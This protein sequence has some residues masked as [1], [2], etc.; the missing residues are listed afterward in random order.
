[1]HDLK[2][3]SILPGEGIGPLH[4]GM[5]FHEATGQIGSYE[6]REL[7][8]ATQIICENFKIW[9]DH[10][11][12]RVAQILAH[13]SF[14]G[15]FDGWLVLGMTLSDVVKRGYS[16]HEELGVYMLDGVDG[17]CMELEDDC[18]LE[19][20]TPWDERAVPIARISVYSAEESV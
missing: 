20:D 10:A 14:E 2:I 18:A 12:D 1:M 9:I 17:M 6:L 3:G 5:T 11:T 4:L 15:A 13:G 7:A 19:D 8:N 16:Y